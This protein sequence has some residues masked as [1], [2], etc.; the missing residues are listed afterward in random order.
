VKNQYRILPK[1]DQDLDE[2]AEY[3]VNESGLEVGL[4][5]LTAAQ[6]TFDLLAAQPTMG[7]RCRLKEP[8][9]ISVRMFPIKR[10]EKFLIFYRL[11]GKCID[12]LRVLHSSQDLKVIFAQ[13]GAIN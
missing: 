11:E 13:K 6:E 10:F 1:A 3:L 7:W 9:L 4:R 8:I 5:F 2:E 12:I